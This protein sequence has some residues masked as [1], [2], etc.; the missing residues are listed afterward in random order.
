EH[1][2]L[3]EFNNSEVAYPQDKTVV[4]IFE[5]H[6]LQTPD[7]IAVVFEGQQLSYRAL[8]ERANRL[9]NYLQ[10]KGVKEKVMVPLLME[11]GADMLIAILGILKAGG[12]YVPV[13][14][15]FPEDRISY[16]LENTGASVVITNSAV[17]NK[18]P[19]LPI[20]VIELDEERS[21]LRQLPSTRPQTGLKAGDPAYV[22]YTSGS[23][24][25]PKGVQINHR[26][27]VDYVFGLDNS[28]HIADCKSFALV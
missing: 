26:N 23:T 4:D 5:E 22:I 28:I 14:T 15:D 20:D 9:A 1:Q 21:T 11:R 2:L 18:L 27:L 3:F 8:N 12:A 24:G 7:A 16:M 19:N 17:S 10:S 13:D 25:K 6:A